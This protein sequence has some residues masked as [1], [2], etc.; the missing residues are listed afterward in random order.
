MPT[1]ILHGTADEV[2]P[3]QVSRDYAASRPWVR[4]VELDSDH[5]LGN[6]EAEI[7]QETRTFLG[8]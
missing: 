8:I 4:L 3:V 7:W 5:A 2:I 1:L 6:V